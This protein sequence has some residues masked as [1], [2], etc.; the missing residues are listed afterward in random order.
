MGERN[1]AVCVI[2]TDLR[3][4]DIENPV[5]NPGAYFHGCI[6][7]AQINEL[8]LFHGVCGELAEA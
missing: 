3:L 2:L 8:K 1:A 6:K 7:K 4:D 5:L